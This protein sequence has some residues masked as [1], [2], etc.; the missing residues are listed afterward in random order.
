[1]VSKCANS[2]CS[3]TFRYLHE[4]AIFHVAIESFGSEKS[5]KCETGTLERFWLCAECSREMTIGSGTAGI[6]VVPLQPRPNPEKQ[7]VPAKAWDSA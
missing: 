3:A 6:L 5:G 2:A 7:A 1:M 4:G